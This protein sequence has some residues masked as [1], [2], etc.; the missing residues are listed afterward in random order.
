MTVGTRCR[1]VE[2]RTPC[3]QQPIYRVVLADCLTCER[4]RG[5]TSCLGHSACVHHGAGLRADRYR[6]GYEDGTDRDVTVQQ[7]SG[8]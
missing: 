4:E 5:T 3:P 6:T 7:I 1:F 2:S 8:T